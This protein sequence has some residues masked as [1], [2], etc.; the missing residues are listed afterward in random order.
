MQLHRA[1]VHIENVLRGAIGERTIW[2]YYFAFGGRYLGVQPLFL[3]GP[4]ARRILWLRRDRG[5]YRTACDAQN[6]TMVVESGGHPNYKPEPEETLY[7]QIVDLSLTRGD[8][9]VNDHRFAMKI[10]FGE[11]LYALPKLARLALTESSEVRSMA[12]FI[13][14]NYSR[15]KSDARLRERAADSVRITKC[16]CARNNSGQMVCQ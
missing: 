4:P 11:P 5:V 15:D 8:G 10:S 1:K 13:L 7:H 6:C 3:Y 14:W 12:C 9:P 16:R 2:V